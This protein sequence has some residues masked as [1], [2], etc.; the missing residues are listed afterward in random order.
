MSGAIATE[1]SIKFDIELFPKQE[2]GSEKLPSHVIKLSVFCFFIHQVQKFGFLIQAAFCTSLLEN[3]IGASMYKFKITFLVVLILTS[4]LSISTALAVTAKAV[5][6]RDSSFSDKWLK[7]LSS[8]N[9]FFKSIGTVYRNEKVYLLL[10]AGNYKADTQ[11]KLNLHY[12]VD[13]IDPNGKNYFSSKNRLISERKVLSQ[14]LLMAEQL[15]FIQ[16]ENNDKLGTYTIKLKINDQVGGQ[17]SSQEIKVKVEEY[18]GQQVKFKNDADFQN[19]QLT[20]YID[21]PIETVFSLLNS[22]SFVAYEMSE[23]AINSSIYFY[24]KIIEQ[25]IFLLPHLEKIM[26][27]KNKRFQDKAL[28]I[29]KTLNLKPNRSDFTKRWKDI[30]PFPDPYGQSPS[31]LFLDMLWSEFFATGSFKPIIKLV[32]IMDRNLASQDPKEYSVGLAAKWSLEASARKFKLVCQYI[33]Y[34]N[35][36]KA[37]E[38]ILDS[39]LVIQNSA[40]SCV[41]YF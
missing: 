14:S 2:Y 7:T 38:N 29:F 19:A 21:Q 25:N 1:S 40:K 35:E 8:E 11:G 20:Y 34:I 28:R 24:Y 39:K 4:F 31:G 10:F 41:Y 26:M 27:K 15:L 13:I 6:S 30:S 37:T 12:D 9:P 36:N 23:D 32:S 33:R 17:S 5:L 16:F 3:K 18:K 22:Y